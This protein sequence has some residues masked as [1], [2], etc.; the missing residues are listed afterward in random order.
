[1]IKVEPI[2]LT[3]A[4]RS[5]LAFEKCL[6]ELSIFIRL[7]VYT[8]TSLVVYLVYQRWSRT[9]IVRTLHSLALIPWYLRYSHSRRTMVL[10]ILWEA[11]YP[12]SLLGSVILRSRVIHPLEARRYLGSQP[13]SLVLETCVGY[14]FPPGSQPGISGQVPFTETVVLSRFR[15]SLTN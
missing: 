3:W 9:W 4:F 14:P 5:Y 13:L 11:I 15:L 6:L 12:S 1:M 8:T 2:F 10:G 7:T